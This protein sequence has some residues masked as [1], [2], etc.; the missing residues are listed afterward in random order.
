MEINA[1]KN[2]LQ[3]FEDDLFVIK[4]PKFFKEVYA[5][6]MIKMG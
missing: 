4:H 1:Y 6:P 5:G 2:N 3:D